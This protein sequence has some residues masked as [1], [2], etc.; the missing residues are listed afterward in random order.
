MVLAH[1]WDQV[2]RRVDLPACVTAVKREATTGGYRSVIWLRH[3]KDPELQALPAEW[4]VAC[5]GH[6]SNPWFLDAMRTLLELC[7]GLASNAFG[8]HLGY[9]VALGKRLHWIEVEAVQNLTALTPAKVREEDLEWAERRRLSSALRALLAEGH[10]CEPDGA[11]WQLLDP[12][13]GFRQVQSPAQL[14]QLLCP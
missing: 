4:I 5:N 14:R 3:W 6:R 2:E 10:L 12:F 8:T 1:S 11:V 13:W 7:D 9:G